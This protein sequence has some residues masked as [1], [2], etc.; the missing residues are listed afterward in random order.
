MFGLSRPIGT[1]APSGLT[2]TRT[3]ALARSWYTSVA[4]SGTSIFGRYH[5]TGDSHNVDS[6]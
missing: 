6:S 3:Y 5:T 4:A 1:G 2:I